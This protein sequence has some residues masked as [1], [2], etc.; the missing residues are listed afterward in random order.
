MPCEALPYSEIKHQKL[1]FDLDVEVML[2]GL[3]VSLG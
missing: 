1:H 2:S 3:V